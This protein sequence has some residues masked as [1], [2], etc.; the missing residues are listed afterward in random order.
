M[1]TQII[2]G[3]APAYAGAASV[4]GG[5][6]MDAHASGV[7][8]GAVFAGAVASAALSL[9]LVILGFGLGL[10]AISPWSYN[11]TLI[12]TSTI[13]W[14]A[15]TQFA[16]SG[17]GGYIAGRLRVKWASVHNDE[18]Y[19]RDTSH[20]LLAW[21]TASLITVVLLTGVVRGAISTTVDASATVVGAAM[22]ALVTAATGPANNAGSGTA[23][24]G[25]T[26]EYFADMILRGNQAATDANPANSRAEINRILLTNLRAGKLAAD[27]RSYLAAIIV[28]RN[29]VTQAEAERKADDIYARAATALEQ[30]KAAAKEAADSARKAAVFAAL[31][32]FIA[33]LLGAF[34][35]S[36]AATL[37]GRQ[38]DAETVY[39]RD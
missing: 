31:W 17:V 28:K 26:V 10:S 11:A 30:A 35:A 13:A 7:S 24:G 19:F 34:V 8:W 20:G 5:G 39:L 15:F 9:I 2:V 18:V 27:D 12:G 36:L 23:A 1:Q 4:K 21:A 25:N 32:A 33:L 22:P 38:R 29:G 16:A 6:A 37:G 3:D 14:L